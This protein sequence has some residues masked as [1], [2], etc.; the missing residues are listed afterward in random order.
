MFA[1]KIWA[2]FASFKDPF[3]ISQNISLNIPPKSSVAG[4]LASILG[5]R[6][7][8]SKEAFR[9]FKYSVI[10]L[11]KIRKKSFSQNY[12]NDYT[13]YTQTQI[14]NLKKRDFKKISSGIRDKKNPQK[15][16]NRELLLDVKYLLFIKDFKYQTQIIN[17]LKERISRFAFY[18]GNSEFAGNFEY[19]PILKAEHKNSCNIKI[20]S[21]ILEED[22]PNI[23][24]REDTRYS[25]LSFASYLD[26]NRS[27]MDIKNIVVADKKIELKEAKYYEIKTDNKLYRCRFV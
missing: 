24:F 20:D 27:P 2:K 1:F 17:N 10:V 13:K 9:E 5:E 14:N 6:D 4:M 25:K 15:P 7:Y 12:I 19:V 11:N 8:S 23:S 18:I 26:Q 3:T 16:I 21:F 22:I